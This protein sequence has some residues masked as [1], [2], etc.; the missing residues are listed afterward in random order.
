[1]TKIHTVQERFQKYCDDK[2]KLF[3]PDELRDPS[4]SRSLF[5]YHQ[6]YSSL[7]VLDK[8]IVDYIEGHE[9]TIT[10]YDFAIV[11][12]KIRERIEHEVELKKEF[13]DLVSSTQQRMEKA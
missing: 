10:I 4:I 1:M 12:G 13:D 3:I 7:D 5:K 9:G 8:C 2:G 11:V 6:K